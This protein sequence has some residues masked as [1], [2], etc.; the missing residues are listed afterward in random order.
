MGPGFDIIGDVHGCA[1]ALEALL[2]SMAYVRRDGV[3]RHPERMAVF[4]G[5]YVDRGAENLRACR[6]VMDMQEA[7][8]ARALMGNHDFNTVCL[9]TCDPANPENFL[10]PHTA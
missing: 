3:W 1:A 9:V 2:R 8:S 5:D 4:V 10:R 6:I 7:G